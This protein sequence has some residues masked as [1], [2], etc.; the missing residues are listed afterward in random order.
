MLTE[1]PTDVSDVSA[2]YNRELKNILD[3]HVPLK[4]MPI[5][6]RTNRDWFTNELGNLRKRLENSTV[7]TSKVNYRQTMRSMT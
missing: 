7:N 3:T 2:H 1:I 4:T 6:E 5:V